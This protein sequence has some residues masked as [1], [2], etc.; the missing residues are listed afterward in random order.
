MRS[1]A[2]L[3][4]GRVHAVLNRLLRTEVLS[5]DSLA[6]QASAKRIPQRITAIVH[7][8]FDNLHDLKPGQYL[9]THKRGSPTVSMYHSCQSNPGSR[10]SI[11]ELTDQ[12]LLLG[13]K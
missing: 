7:H 5:A 9:L 13:L 4:V 6:Q 3:Q 8:L 10:V 12:L 1:K 2:I 11:S